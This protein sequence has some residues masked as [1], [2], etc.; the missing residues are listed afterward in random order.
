MHNHLPGSRILDSLVFNKVKDATG[1]RLRVCVTAAAPIARET[2]EF[3]SMTIA[4]VINAY[5]ST[6]TCGYVY[7]RQDVYLA[8]FLKVI[9][10]I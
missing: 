5:G 6:E 10:F 2:Q 4:P 3:I 8:I 7:R 1:G 9:G